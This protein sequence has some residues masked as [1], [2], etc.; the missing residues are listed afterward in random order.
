MVTA[1]HNENGWT[2]VKMGANKPLTFGPEEMGRLKD[3]VLNGKF[4]PQPG[5][6]LV[7]VDGMRERYIADVT[8][9]VKLSRKLKVVCACGNGAAGAFAPDALR[10]MGAK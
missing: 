3:I 6:K 4:N 2:G 7:R 5:G 1:S 10:A 8:K 9:G